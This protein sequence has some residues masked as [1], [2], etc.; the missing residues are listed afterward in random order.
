[1][2]DDAPILRGLKVLD[3]AS[4]IAGPA[5]TTVMADHGA[6]VIK[7][8][9]PGG[10]GYRTITTGPG[11]PKASVDY[12]WMVDN[13]TKRGLQLDLRQDAARQVMTKLVAEADVLV[14]NFVPRVREQLG[15]RYADLKP[16][17]ERLI[18]ASM[19]AYGEDG[20]E[21]GRT[22]FDST[23][24]WA[25]TGLMDLVRPDPDG[26]PARSLPGM[27]DHPT[28]IALFGAIMLGLHRRSLTGKGGQVS[29]SLI[30]N[31]LWSNAFYAQA[32]LAEGE[33]PVRPRRDNWPNAL[34]NHYKSRDGRWF[35]L[36]LINEDREWDR[37]A[38]GV[39]RPELLSD[40]RF[41]DRTARHANAAA[42][43]AILTEVFVEKDW[44]AWRAL[45]DDLRITFGLIGRVQDLAADQ[46]VRPSGAVR[47]VDPALFG[48]DA[49]IDSP[50]FVAEAARRAP[51][52]AP[53]VG[54]HSDEI[55]AELGYDGAAIRDL[56]ASG[57]VG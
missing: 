7:I 28:A 4:F 25:R 23:A 17:N 8:E 53:A 10:D 21:A 42:L 14:T 49:M 27:G 5:A 37:F 33:I 26:P 30:A 46:Q 44:E 20:P 31:G 18:Y 39:G 36:S 24:Y 29:T 38:E 40:E 57:A 22:G 16:I 52:P 19:T 34:A 50:I 35:M 15:L 11:M 13:R 1:M 6:D 56:R 54:Q 45:F 12:H 41:T 2:G 43:I 51:E 55:L 3:V 47:P 48:V 9:A 32:A